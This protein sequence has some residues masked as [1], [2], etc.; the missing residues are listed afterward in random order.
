MMR[1]KVTIKIYCEHGALT[2]TLRRLKGEKRIELV[3]YPYD[4]NSTS[5]H[6]SP[7]AACWSSNYENPFTVKILS[8]I[9]REALPR[10]GVHRRPRHAI[11]HPCSSRAVHLTSPGA[12]DRSQ[13][14]RK[15]DRVQTRVRIPLGPLE[16]RRSAPGALRVQPLSV[17]LEPFSPCRRRRR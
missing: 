9:A 8:L 14:W 13:S 7:S 1:A 11:A 15:R 6:I 10:G 17:G 5:K 4:E 2:P 12:V 16:I 3:H